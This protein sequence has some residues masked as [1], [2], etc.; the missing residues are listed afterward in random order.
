MDRWEAVGRLGLLLVIAVTHRVARSG[1]AYG[2]FRKAV[3]RG[4]AE[5]RSR[6]R[7]S[8]RNSDSRTRLTSSSTLARAR[9][10]RTSSSV[11]PAGGSSFQR[12]S[13]LEE[14]FPH[15]EQATG[16]AI[17][18]HRSQRGR[19]APVCA[20]VAPQFGGIRRDSAG[21]WRERTAVPNRLLSPTIRLRQA[22]RA[23]RTRTCNPRFWRP[24]LCQLSYGPSPWTG[25]CTGVNR[26]P[27]GALFV[28]LAGGF[29]GIGFVAAQAGGLAWAIAVPAV[30]LAVWMG[31]LAFR[32]LR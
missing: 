20:P 4:N 15:S 1:S 29:G 13:G 9:S 28:L 7:P 16:S 32:M 8:S 17:S 2:R 10:L 14:S 12:S 19:C 18:Q 3:D 5:P 31:E 11:F 30:L 6:R 25:H 26:R 21:S 22:N 27:L 24:V 23:G